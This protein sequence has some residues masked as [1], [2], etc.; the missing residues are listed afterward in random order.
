MNLELAGLKAIGA[1]EHL[2]QAQIAC[3]KPDYPH[4]GWLGRQ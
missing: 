1:A 3:S 2:P 4:W